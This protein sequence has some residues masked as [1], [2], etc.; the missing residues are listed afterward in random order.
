[1]PDR[2]PRVYGYCRASTSKQ[3][4]STDTQKGLIR[5]YADAQK[6]GDITWCVDPATSGKTPLGERIAGRSLLNAVRPGDVVI[7]SKLDRMF[8]ST[9]DGCTVLDEF[10]RRGVKL[11]VCNLMGGAVDL[12]SAM[13]MFFVQILTAFAE[14][15]RAFI[16]E[17]TKDG[18]AA[19]K[20]QRVRHTR[21]AGYGFTWLRRKG[22]DG[23]PER[24]R[25]SCPEEREVM[26]AIVR[27][28][29]DHQLTWP[30]IEAHLSKHNAFMKDGI[31]WD[32]SRIRRAYQA[33]LELRLAEQR[34]NR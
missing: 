34:N 7:I 22:A 14:L 4:D 32:Q 1:M 2:P 29:H 8:R 12:S 17:R 13:G 9:K 16:S 33:E 5:Q 30:E 6:L 19:K 21:H 11:H 25:V 20:S 15:E 10:K 18:L 24:V 23:K 28:R 27:Y 31:R 3:A 26:A